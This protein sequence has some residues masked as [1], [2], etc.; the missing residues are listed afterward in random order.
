[1]YKEPKAFKSTMN[2]YKK[3]FHWDGCVRGKPTKEN[4]SA[5]LASREVQ[6]Q[7]I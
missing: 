2:K 6:I 7:T 1:M 4:M 3:G 5:S